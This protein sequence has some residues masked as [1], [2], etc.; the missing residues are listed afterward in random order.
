MP[1]YDLRSIKADIR[2]A[3]ETRIVNTHVKRDRF[4]LRNIPSQEYEM[5]LTVWRD[6]YRDI[7]DIVRL[8]DPLY[9]ELENDDS[10]MDDGIDEE[11][12]VTRDSIAERLNEI[13]DTI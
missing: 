9:S 3:F 11:I 13:V 8:S 2:L 5:D 12:E 7:M 10:E 1:N 4:S 6:A